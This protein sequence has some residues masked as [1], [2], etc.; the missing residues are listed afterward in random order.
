MT[1]SPRNT[2]SIKGLPLTSRGQLHKEFKRC[3]KEV[4]YRHHLE[5]I[6]IVKYTVSTLKWESRWTY[7][8]IM[9]KV[10]ISVHK[11]YIATVLVLL[12]LF[13]KDMCLVFCPLLCKLYL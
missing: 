7:L 11:S 13:V 1:R 3:Y 6:C 2:Y 4:S 5:R 9:F 12:E 8:I 10:P